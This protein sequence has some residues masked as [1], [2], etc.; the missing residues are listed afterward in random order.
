M[1]AGIDGQR[2][3]KVGR[4]DWCPVVSVVGGAEDAAAAADCSGKDVAAVIAG[5]GQDKTTGQAGVDGRPVGA[6]VRGAEDA[7][8]EAPASDLPALSQRP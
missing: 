5:Q 3:N 2:A 4:Q 7:A 1:P 8:A 6:V